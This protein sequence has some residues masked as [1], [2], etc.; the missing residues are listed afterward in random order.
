M[1]NLVPLILLAACANQ[2]P[3]DTASNAPTSGSPCTGA[4]CAGTTSTQ[5]GTPAGT[6]GGTTGGTP[7]GTATGTPA[8]GDTFELDLAGATLSQPS[9]ISSLVGSFLADPVLV[10]V[11][12]TSPALDLRA[13]AT[14]GVNQERCQP[15][16]DSTGNDFSLAPVFSAP[17][18]PLPIRSTGVPLP[19]DQA[20]LTGDYDASTQTMTNVSLTGVMDVSSLAPL[21][22]SDP[23]LLLQTFGVTCVACPSG[24]VSCLDIAM[25]AIPASYR[26]DS[27]FLRTDSDIAA[28]PSCP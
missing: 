9:G 1:R 5:G 20:V 12:A 8:T 6:P 7:T 11:L 10:E 23:C 4:T 15:T 13:A 17:F 22:G 26:T 24:A 3:Q 27:L 18:D 2:K 14:D 28:D 16:T 25:D 19:L 21:V